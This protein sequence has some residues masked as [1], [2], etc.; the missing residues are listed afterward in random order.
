MRKAAAGLPHSKSLLRDTMR[1]S[2]NARASWAKAGPCS[3]VAAMSLKFDEAHQGRFLRLN[4]L[5]SCN[6]VQ[7]GIDMR[8]MVGGDVAHEGAH[9]FVVAH[10]AMQPAQEEDELHADGNER[11]QD[12]GPVEGHAG[13]FRSKG[14]K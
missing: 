12:S 3:V 6:R 2:V 9:D 10:A 7:R 4:S 8:Q 14:S 13:T 11:G 5:L 1:D